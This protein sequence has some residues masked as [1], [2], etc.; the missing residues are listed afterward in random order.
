MKQAVLMILIGL[1]LAAEAQEG[2][3]PAGAGELAA[4]LRKFDR[5]KDGKLSGEELKLAR[6]AHNRGGRD[7]EPGPGRWREILERQER[8]FVRRRERDFDANGDGK[9][10][11]HERSEMRGVWKRI[12]DQFVELR[13]TITAKYDRNDDGELNERER[14]ASRQESDRLRREIE[15]RCLEEWRAKA[16]PKP[17]TGAVNR[18]ATADF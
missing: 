12:A 9:V 16:V 7:A 6:Q 4:P 14:N 2:A 11:D 17:G 13:A 5:D 15:D 18:T 8:E 10:D 3:K 1:C